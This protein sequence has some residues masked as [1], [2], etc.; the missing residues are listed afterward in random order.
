MTGEN[1]LLIIIIV[2]IAIWLYIRIQKRV[3]NFADIV[4]NFLSFCKSNRMQLI[5]QGANGVL[6]RRPLNIEKLKSA[7]LETYQIEPHL[8]DDSA[9]YQYIGISC[10]GD[11]SALSLD[12]RKPDKTST[13]FFFTNYLIVDG[14]KGNIES[15]KQELYHWEDSEVF[16]QK[17]IERGY[18]DLARQL[19]YEI[20]EAQRGYGWYAE[21][22]K[23]EELAQWREL[24]S[25]VQVPIYFRTT[26]EDFFIPYRISLKKFLVNRDAY[27]SPTFIIEYDGSPLLSKTLKIFLEDPSLRAMGYPSWFYQ[28]FPDVAMWAIK[29]NGNVIVKQMFSN[30]T[31]GAV[32][33]DGQLRPEILK[34]IYFNHK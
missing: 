12:D 32:V 34:K 21:L 22:L 2:G 30:L 14:Y 27:N 13:S 18:A 25:D 31:E 17:T 24:A 8:P 1:V 33:V 15:N 4:P 6:F 11:Y 29:G 16:Y 3:K 19:H 20:E 5:G 10:E 9:L 7:Y 28:S 23:N 26:I